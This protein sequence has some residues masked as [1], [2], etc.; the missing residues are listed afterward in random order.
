[1]EFDYRILE[2]LSSKQLGTQVENDDQRE[3]DLHFMVLMDDQE[4]VEA[5]CVSLA[6]LYN[7]DQQITI[8]E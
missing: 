5:M 6:Q 8:Y 1:M 4:K 7:A 2:N 3:T